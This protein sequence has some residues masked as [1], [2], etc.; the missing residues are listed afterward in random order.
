MANIESDVTDFIRI[1][2]CDLI[3]WAYRVAERAGQTVP[4][5]RQV[6]QTAPNT[7][8]RQ[9]LFWGATWARNRLTHGDAELLGLAMSADIDR[10]FDS[11]DI[12]FD[13]I[14][15]TYNGDLVDG[16]TLRFTKATMPL[17]GDRRPDL[18]PFYNECIS[19][20]RV[21]VVAGLLAGKR[22]F[23]G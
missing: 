3:G 10:S 1:T 14:E 19:G 20:R 21:V 9:H 8:N 15:V 13:D 12:L 23:A 18:Q 11:P 6:E 2:A 4:P 7:A 5:R 17:S 16:R 22:T